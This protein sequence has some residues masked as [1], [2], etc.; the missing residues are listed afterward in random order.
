[1]KKI[2]DA[3]SDVLIIDGS[4]QTNR[5]NMHILDIV[6]I[7][8]L[9]KTTTCFFALLDNQKSDSFSWALKNFKNQMQMEPTIIFSDD[10]EALGKGLN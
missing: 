7:N 8:N 10:E 2:A 9:G 6:A 1:M 3:F 4:H 5:F